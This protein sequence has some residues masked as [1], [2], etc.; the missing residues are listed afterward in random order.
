MRLK[1]LTVK[2][3]CLAIGLAWSVPSASA[4]SVSAPA[5]VPPDA[6]QIVQPVQW[7]PPPPPRYGPPRYGP[8]PYGPPRYGP[9]RYG[10]PRYGPPPRWRRP[11]PPG[12]GPRRPY[13]GPPPVR[14]GAPRP[15]TREWYAYC[16]SKYRS[17]DPRT[18]T[19]RPYNG[20]RRLCR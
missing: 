2:I 16:S 4:A 12:W 5:V 10:P 7:G 14:Y 18:G 17:F 8:P 11:P 9:P 13:Y 15:W 1:S 6:A 19:Y 3:C 20:P